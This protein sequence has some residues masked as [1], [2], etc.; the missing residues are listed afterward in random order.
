MYP[1][2]IDL[3]VEYHRQEL[4]DEVAH[5]RL[6]AQLPR[7]SG[8]AVRHGLALACYR[9]ASWLDGEWYARPAESGREDWVHESAPA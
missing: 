4:E 8:G 7:R 5:A 3:F 9:A 1:H 6:L 2:Q